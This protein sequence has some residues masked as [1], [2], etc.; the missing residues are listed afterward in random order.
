[1]SPTIDEVVEELEARL[2]AVGLLE[3]LEFWE[4]TSEDSVGNVKVRPQCIA[5]VGR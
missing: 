3:K 1:M 5:L 4:V 2:S